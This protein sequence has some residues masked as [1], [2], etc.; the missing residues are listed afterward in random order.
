MVVQIDT[1][2]KPKAIAAIL[3]EFDRQGVRSIR[4]KMYVG[5]YMDI[6]NPHIVIDRKQSILEIAGNATSQHDR[7]K[8]ELMRLN[9]I[10][11]SMVVLIEQNRYKDVR[12][13]WV[14]VRE[15]SDLIGWKNPRGMVDGPRI[16]QILNAWEH[17]HPVRFE[18]CRS[19]QT[20]RRILEI[21][22]GR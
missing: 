8:R 11:A 14:T 17:K 10:G 9:D 21:L 5:D 6:E 22:D 15:I 12:G 18:F 1:R 3:E 19:D 2:E 20:G 16:Y 7:F 13:E 4:S